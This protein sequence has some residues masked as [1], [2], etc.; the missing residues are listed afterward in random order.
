[1]DSTTPQTIAQVVG[2]NA[3]QLRGHHKIE[4]VA[5][6]A[7]MVGLKWNSGRVSDL[8]NGRISPTLPTLFALAHALGSVADEPVSIARLVETPNLVR[9]NDGL[10]VAGTDVA[11][12]VMGE[13]VAIKVG[14]IPGGKERASRALQGAAESQRSMPAHLDDVSIPDLERIEAESSETEQRIAR[15][16]GID[17]ARMNAESAHLWRDTF[18][19]ERDRRA[20][21]TAKQQTRG[22]ISR[23]LKAELKA[24]IDRG[25]DQ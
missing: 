12:A 15:G 10:V 5:H 19:G 6:A 21:P 18:S 4:E 14:D 2:A 17:D 22:H 16:L 25:N 24:S 11:Q 7:K 1:M 9:I 3:R 13:P 20:G 8:E 23:Q